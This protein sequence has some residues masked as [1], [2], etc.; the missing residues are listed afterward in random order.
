MSEKCNPALPRGTKWSSASSQELPDSSTPDWRNHLSLGSPQHQ[1][2]ILESFPAVSVS[3]IELWAPRHPVSP[4]LTLCR[5]E[6]VLHK[7]LSGNWL[8]L[9]YKMFN[10]RNLTWNPLT[11]WKNLP[12]FL[13]WQGISRSWRIEATLGGY[14]NHR[15]VTQSF[16]TLI[17]SKV[18]WASCDKHM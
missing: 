8:C 6:W 3:P 15:D 2:C 16:D 14:P 12:P 17:S 5:A 11:P 1:E 9:P 10:S 13:P 4:G 18:S 7:C